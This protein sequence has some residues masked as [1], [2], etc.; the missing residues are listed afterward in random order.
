VS[1]RYELRFRPAAAKILRKLP[2]DVAK[3][4][5][6]ATEALQ[7]DPRPTGATA[8]QGQQGLLRVRVGDYRVVYDVNDDELVVLVIHLGHR[9]EV[10]RTI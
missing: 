7:D 9:R 4:I 3:R 5:K 1:R 10:Y 6:T 2:R 8:L